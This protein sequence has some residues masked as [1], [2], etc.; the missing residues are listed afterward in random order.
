[1]KTI[2]S[3][4]VLLFLFITPDFYGQEFGVVAGLTESGKVKVR[5]FSSEEFNDEGVVLFRREKNQNEWTKLTQ[6]PIKKIEKVSPDIADTSLAIASSIIYNIPDNSEDR[7]TYELILLT[8]GILDDKFSL[9]YGMQYNDENIVEGKTYEYKVV[10]I[11]DSKENL[12]AVSEPVKIDKYSA[13]AA[14][15]KL[16]AFAK[17]GIVNFNWERDENRFFVYNIY[18]GENQN[19]RKTL[20]NNT[21][22]HVFE[23]PDSAG[24]YHTN[25]FFYSDT[26]LTNGVTYYYELTG[27]DYLGRESKR[28]ATIAV[29][30]KDLTPPPAPTKVRATAIKNDVQITWKSIYVKDL[31]GFNI[32]RSRDFKGPYN[33]I[34]KT[35]IDKS[36][37]SY[38]DKIASPEER[39]YYYLTAEDNSSNKSQSLSTIAQIP[40][41][42]AP[43]KPV[44]LKALGEVGL[45]K[46]S[47]KKGT[48]KDLLGYF[49]YRS[50]TNT[51]DEFVLLNPKPVNAVSYVDTLKKESRNYFQYKIVAV[52]K[53]YNLSPYSDVVNV[54]LK[55][56]TPPPAPKLVNADLTDNYILL[57]WVSSTV[58]D[59]AGHFVYRS[60]KDDSSKW[61]Q[62]N[63][64]QLNKE[65]DTY[66]DSMMAGGIY[67]Y[68]VISIDSAGNKSVRSN[69]LSAEY[70]INTT[71]PAVEG[72]TQKLSKNKNEVSLSWSQI[73]GDNLLGYVVFRKE[74][75]SDNF[76]NAISPLQKENTFVDKD[77]SLGKTFYYIV[78]AFDTKGNIS[79][80]KSAKL[81]VK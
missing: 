33:K 39:Y 69:I 42:E 52:D 32:F 60:A 63:K 44:N 15:D 76:D 41:W 40:D 8:K 47:W 72:F 64:I 10:M 29:T 35:L 20:I 11:K 58:E 18:R 9:A 36:D 7:E 48:E 54:K 6:E 12:S 65:T 16:N 75:E 1:M 25:E 13:S 70:F 62:L 37:T 50:V 51:E 67:F 23:F 31:K 49:I 43:A 68:C 27:T 22:I 78:K 57:Q 24:N 4:I 26:G 77:I 3:A 46:L 2:I 55:D 28:S 17:D 19:S 30:P 14:P 38:V 53:K 79:E 56:L 73:K 34:N 74:N 81:E 71:F 5:W 45:V 66:K 21:P 59:I 80:S 61:N